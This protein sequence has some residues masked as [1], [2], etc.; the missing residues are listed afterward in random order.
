[1]C[2]CVCVLVSVLDVDCSKSCFMVA[3]NARLAE[4][5]MQLASFGISFLCKF[6]SF[7]PL[8]SMPRGSGL[9][10]RFA[11]GRLSHAF[12]VQSLTDRS[13]R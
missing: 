7:D 6:K 4:W 8:G 13:S 12:T 10:I 9:P 3:L 11:V 5:G 2:A 1:M